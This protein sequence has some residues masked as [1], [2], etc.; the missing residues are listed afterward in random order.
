MIVFYFYGQEVNN[1]F[2]RPGGE[3]AK[4]SE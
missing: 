1:L 3:V 2:Q 4:P